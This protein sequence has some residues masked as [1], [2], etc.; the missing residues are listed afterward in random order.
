MAEGFLKH[1]LGPK[2]D[3]R[4][5]GIEAHGLN[6]KAV[7]V[8]GEAG[9]DISHHTSKKLDE[10]SGETFDFVVTVCDSTRESCPHFPAKTKTIHRN[11]PD[12]AKAT[13]SSEEILREFSRVRDEI[14]EFCHDFIEEYLELS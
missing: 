7:E 1:L 14:A 8:M 5:A 12:P 3:V 6:P 9:I 2:A 11:F 10:Y 13:G 4:S